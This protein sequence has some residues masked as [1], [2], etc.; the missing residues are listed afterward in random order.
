MAEIEAMAFPSIAHRQ[1]ILDAC[2]AAAPSPKQ[3]DPSKLTDNLRRRWHAY[4]YGWRRVFIDDF[5][6]RSVIDPKGEWYD[7]GLALL[8]EQMY[9][10]G[11]RNNDAPDRL[12]PN[13]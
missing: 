8:A 13:D 10:A 12:R 5:K 6:P 9:R 4:D 1:A 7:A 2:R 3:V 11:V